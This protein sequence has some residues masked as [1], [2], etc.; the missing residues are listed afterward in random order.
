MNIDRTPLLPEANRPQ[1]LQKYTESSTWDII[2]KEKLSCGR[3]SYYSTDKH[4]TCCSRFEIYCGV[5]KD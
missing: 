5:R 3:K 2:K 1:G 4:E